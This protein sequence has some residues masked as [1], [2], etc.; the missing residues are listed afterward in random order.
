MITIKVVNGNSVVSLHKRALQT[1]QSASDILK[2]GGTALHPEVDEL[3]KGLDD[4]IAKASGTEAKPE[5][6]A[7]SPELTAAI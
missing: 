3:R 5:E 1:L 6:P 7:E 4:V 2:V